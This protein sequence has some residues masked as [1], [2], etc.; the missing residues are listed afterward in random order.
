MRNKREWLMKDTKWINLI[1]KRMELN[2]LIIL[3]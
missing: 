1:L 3:K 2:V